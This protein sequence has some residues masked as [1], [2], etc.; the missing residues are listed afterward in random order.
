MNNPLKLQQLREYESLAKV[1]EVDGHRSYCSLVSGAMLAAAGAA[2]TIVGSLALVFT[3]GLSLPVSG[4]LIG[5]GA[6]LLVGGSVLFKKGMQTGTVDS[7]FAVTKS[8]GKFR[9]FPQRHSSVDA[10]TTA[11]PSAPALDEMRRVVK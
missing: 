11:Q 9:F 2:L 4:T 6:F 3:L 8:A 5:V 1:E 10:N 7:I